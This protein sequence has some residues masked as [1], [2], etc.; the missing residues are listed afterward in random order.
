MKKL[1][2]LVV[3][4][5]NEEEMAPIFHEAVSKLLDNL[6]EK[7]DVE[8]V[9]VN[10]GSKDKTWEIIK[11]LKE[12]DNRV[13]A[14]CLSRNFG[15]EAAIAAGL[16][17]CRGEACIIMDADLQDS[18]E[19]IE[20]MLDKFEEGYEVVNAK[21]TDRKKDSFL[22]RF[23]AKKYYDVIYKL[24]GKVKVP[25]NVNNFR[26]LSRKVIDQI[27]ALP[28]K[29]RV[30]RILVP[31][32]GYKTAEVTFAR[33]RRPKGK[34]KY[35]PTALFSLAGESIVATSFRPLLWPLKFGLGLTFLSFIAFVTTLVFYI[36]GKCHIDPFLFWDNGLYLLISIIALLFGILF[37]FLGIVAQYVGK[38]YLE[39]RDRPIFFIE[40]DLKD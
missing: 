1:I 5:Y 17:V 38:T 22:K 37:I 27:N 34:S 28:E 39:A 26:L 33:Q 29:N 2:S 9:Y 23:T 30:F 12:K 35:N 36:L 6:K 32:V 40:E 25:K 18:P 14:V 19:V 16:S 8:Y 3:P 24:S 13:H 15:Q 11:S 7:Y 20:K 4:M 10:D 21:R 31:Y